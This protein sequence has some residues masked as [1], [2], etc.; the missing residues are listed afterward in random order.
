MTQP[1]SKAAIRGWEDIAAWEKASAVTGYPRASKAA[2]QYALINALLDMDA[3]LGFLN[4]L[5]PKTTPT[6]V[7][8]LA[9]LLMRHWN[10]STRYAHPTHEWLAQKTG[11][12]AS[13]LDNAVAGLRETGLIGVLSG[14]KTATE[15]VASRYYPLFHQPSRETFI[16]ALNTRDQAAV[17]NLSRKVTALEAKVARLNDAERVSESKPP[18]T[19]MERAAADLKAMAASHAS[20]LIW[21]LPPNASKQSVIH[22]LNALPAAAFQG[23]ASGRISRA[24]TIKVALSILELT[25]PGK[26]FASL[27]RE[28]LA[29]AADCSIGTVRMALRSLRRAGLIG[30]IEGVGRGNRSDYYVLV[31]KNTILAFTEAVHSTDFD[32]DDSAPPF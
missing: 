17:I 19:G 25:G 2:N 32:M 4:D 7:R 16:E 18:S 3:S 31:H 1:V 13:A 12:S 15:S 24:T 20:G 6:H 28:E 26:H 5:N 22:T 21:H 23:S 8:H 14:Y 27:T 29:E 10:V 30:V 11:W 9:L